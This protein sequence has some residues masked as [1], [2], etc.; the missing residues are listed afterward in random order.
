MKKDELILHPWRWRGKKM[1]VMKL[2]MLMVLLPVFAFAM[3]TYSQKQIKMEVQ[4]VSLEQVLKEHNLG[5]IF[6]IINRMYRG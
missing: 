6:C 3:P 5:I 4:D 1:L 2:V